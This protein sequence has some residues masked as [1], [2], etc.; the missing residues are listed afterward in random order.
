MKRETGR[1]ELPQIVSMDGG[2][3]WELNVL[4]TG[5]TAYIFEK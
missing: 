1:F 3:L 4:K 2:D 5:N